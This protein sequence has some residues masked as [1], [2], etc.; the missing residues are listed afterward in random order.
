MAI[1]QSSRVTPLQEVST[2][3]VDYLLTRQR[4]NQASMR[5]P[6]GLLYKLNIDGAWAKATG[7]GGM[8]IVIKD[9]KGMFI[10]GMAKEIPFM[11]SSQ[12][13]EAI[14]LREGL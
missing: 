14:A 7:I 9:A 1:S 10:A 12:M 5:P 13:V 6:P 8:S 3:V 11:R 2:R 4:A